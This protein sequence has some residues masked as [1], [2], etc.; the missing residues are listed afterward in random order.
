MAELKIANYGPVLKCTYTHTKED[1]TT[2]FVY[3]STRPNGLGVHGALSDISKTLRNVDAN[4]E[5]A[6]INAP[7]LTA[8]QIASLKVYLRNTN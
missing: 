6:V 8:S 5:D 3:F 2:S 4:I 1:N 7:D